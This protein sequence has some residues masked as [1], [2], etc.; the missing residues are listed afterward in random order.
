MYKCVYLHIYIYSAHGNTISLQRN[1][2]KETQKIDY[3]LNST[4]KLKYAFLRIGV[5]SIALSYSIC[6][7]FGYKC[8]SK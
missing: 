3:L 4:L 1:A 7:N 8:L 5:L 6:G 2:R